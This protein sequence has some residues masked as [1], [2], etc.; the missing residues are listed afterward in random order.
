MPARIQRYRIYSFLKLLLYYL[1]GSLNYIL[2]F[3]YFSYSIMALLYET[4]LIFQDIQ[5]KYLG[6]LGKYRYV[7]ID[8]YIKQHFLLKVI[9]CCADRMVIENENINNKEHRT[10]I[11]RNWYT[12]AAG[13]QLTIGRLYY[14]LAILSRPQTLQQF[15]FFMLNRSRRLSFFYPCGNL[16]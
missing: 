10:V 8:F 12:K 3:I 1:P 16:S 4:V 7:Q 11:S 9:N 2:F 5:V 6:N 14:Y 15:F 13:R